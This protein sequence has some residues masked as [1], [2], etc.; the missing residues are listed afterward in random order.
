MLKEFFKFDI[1]QYKKYVV[2]EIFSK[3]NIKPFVITLT[4]VMVGLAVH[5]VVVAPR[6]KAKFIDK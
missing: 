5:Q 3:A 6:L 4:A 1:E 2:K